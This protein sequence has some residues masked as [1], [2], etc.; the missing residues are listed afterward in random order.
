ME[1]PYK[2][3]WFLSYS[4]LELLNS[5]EWNNVYFSVLWEK[6]QLR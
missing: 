5:N 2:A 1:F 6:S 4:T 3:L